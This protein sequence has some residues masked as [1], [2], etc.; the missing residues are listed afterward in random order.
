ML[1]FPI[2]HQSIGDQIAD[3]LNKYNNLGSL[4]NG[5]NILNGKTHYVVETHGN[6]VIGAAGIEKTSYHLSEFKHLV[7]H[8]EWRNKKIGCFL[9]KRIISICQTPLLF[10]TARLNNHASLKTL[11]KLGFKQTE[12]FKVGSSHLTFLLKASSTCKNTNLKSDSF[13]KMMWENLMPPLQ[14]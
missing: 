11:G 9:G 1:Y 10:A 3:L 13:E 14:E 7:V 5:H 4:R 2:S 8:P 12:Q 6:H